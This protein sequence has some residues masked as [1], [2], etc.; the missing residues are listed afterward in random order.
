MYK[1]GV[2][3]PQEVHSCPGQD[4]TSSLTCLSPR[5]GIPHPVKSADCVWPVEVWGKWE[6]AVGMCQR[7]SCHQCWLW[8]A[9]VNLPLKNMAPSLVHSWHTSYFSSLT[10][11][12]SG[13]RDQL[14]LIQ[15][16][17]VQFLLS[18]SY[19]RD[20]SLFPSVVLLQPHCP[21]TNV[22]IS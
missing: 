21:R 14:S 1:V 10:S 2:K 19:Y 17:P 3:S 13:S 18:S 6:A 5:V 12:E 7:T 15:G 22:W 8:S 16:K 20:K 4:P 9:G 11:G